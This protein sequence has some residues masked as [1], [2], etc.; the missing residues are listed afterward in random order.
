M[1]RRGLRGTYG[2]LARIQDRAMRLE[3]LRLL[4]LRRPEVRVTETQPAA[5][6]IDSIEMS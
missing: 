5:P 1:K 3:S 4:K 2:V 6:A